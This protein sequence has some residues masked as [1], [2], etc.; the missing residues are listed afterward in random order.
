MTHPV[1]PKHPLAEVFGFPI[2]NDSPEAR[3]FRKSKLCPFNN[4]NNKV[5][6]CRVM[7]QNTHRKNA[8][9]FVDPP[10]TAGGK[11]A[12]SRL[13]AHWQL[14][15]EEL[16]R[17]TSRLAGD[18]LMTYEDADEVRFLAAKYGFDTEAISMKTTHHAHLKELLIG[19]DLSWVRR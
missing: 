1:T 7:E 19:P 17:V 5:P 18:F 9:F 15:H 13:Y 4:F 12:G 16:F 14:D 10:Y 8:V 2:S 11:N 6:N 3:R